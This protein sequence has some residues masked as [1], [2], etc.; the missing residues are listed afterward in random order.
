[1]LEGTN[2]YPIMLL[3]AY[4]IL[5]CWESL[6]AGGLPGNDGIALTTN[7]GSSGAV[8]DGGD[9]TNNNQYVFAQRVAAPIPQSW[10]VL[11]STATDTVFCNSQLL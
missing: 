6:P 7:T 11:D 10:L 3:D 4:T 8:S 9:A 2:Q 1:M 5:Q